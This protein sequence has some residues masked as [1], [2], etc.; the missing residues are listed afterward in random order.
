[1]SFLKST[2]LTASIALS[3]APALAI[4]PEEVWADWQTLIQNYGATLEMGEETRAG[5]SLT[6]TDVTISSEMPDGAFDMVLGDITFTNIGDGAVRVDMSDELPFRIEITSDDG[7]TGVV[8]FTL[9]QPGA[10][11]TASGSADKLRYDFDY[12]VLG[13]G[14]FDMSG[15]DVPDDLPLT[16]DMTLANMSGFIDLAGDNPRTYESESAVEAFTLNM[17]FDEMDGENPGSGEIALSMSDLKQTTIGAIATLNPG[18]SLSEMAAAGLRQTGTASHG[19]LTYSVSFAG[20]EGSFE[21]AAAAES[22][23]IEGGLDASGLEYGG[24]T[25][26]VTVTVGGSQIPL[27]PVTLRMAQSGGLFRMPLIPGEDPQDFALVVRMQDLEVDDMLWSIFD[28]MSALPRDPATLV[29][30]LG[31]TAIMSEDFTSPEFAESEM[32]EAPG[33][34]ESL[35][36]N[37]LQLSVAGAELTG[38]GAFIFNNESG[39]PMPAGTARLMLI[40]GNALLDRLVGMGLVPEEQAMGARMML[41][42]FARPEGED[43]LVSDIEVT[44]DGQVLANGQRIR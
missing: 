40:G 20:P 12:P 44:E 36:V 21:M 38:N 5:E 17:A 33:Q 28:P 32:A 27:P 23:T 39:M 43:T 34:L 37:A 2:T 1:M 30:D 14:D 31:G 18:A 24:T 11:M 16:F 25:N 9:T 7:E 15:P 26:N 42:L 3:A 41:G 29:I 6:V 10:T 19:P 4:T 13:M 22:G 35:D 8:S